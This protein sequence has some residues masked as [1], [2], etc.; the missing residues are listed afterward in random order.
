MGSQ[1]EI[2]I[3]QAKRGYDVADDSQNQVIWYNPYV[4]PYTHFKFKI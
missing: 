4:S 1:G 2:R 3:N